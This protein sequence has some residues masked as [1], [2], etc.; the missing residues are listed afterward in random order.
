MIPEEVMLA[1]TPWLCG[2]MF[3]VFSGWVI[4]AL[5]GGL[6]EDRRLQAGRRE[7]A[8]QAEME[9]QSAPICRPSVS[10]VP[11]VRATAMQ[12]V[13]EYIREGAEAERTFHET[14]EGKCYTRHKIA[15]RAARRL[16]ELGDTAEGRAF[17]SRWSVKFAREVRY[18]WDLEES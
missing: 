15:M 18:A 4:W 17:A 2:G 1:L 7:E 12:S 16:Q 8:R 11:T 3:L 14:P 6:E 10:S 9:Q 5:F 13:Q